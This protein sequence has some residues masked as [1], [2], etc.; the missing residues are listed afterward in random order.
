M[1]SVPLGGVIVGVPDGR[2]TRPPTTIG[3]FQCPCAAGSDDQQR[4]CPAADSSVRPLIVHVQEAAGDHRA[5]AR[6]AV[7]PILAGAGGPRQDVRRRAGVVGDEH[8]VARCR[9]RR[10]EHLSPPRRTRLYSPEPGSRAAASLELSRSSSEHAV[11]AALD[12]QLQPRLAAAPPAP[13]CRGRC[14]SRSAAPGSSASSC[15]VCAGVRA[16]LEHAVAPVGRAVERPVSG[17]DQDRRVPAR[18]RRRHG[19][20]SRSR[21]VSRAG[22]RRVDQ[23]VT[24]RALRVPDRDVIRSIPSIARHGL[25]RAGCRRSTRRSRRSRAPG[26]VQPPFDLLVPRVE[27]DPC[28]PGL[29]TRP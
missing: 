9:P 23:L 10:G 8:V 3:L 17:R 18:P 16:Q 4:R 21:L 27:R 7:L 6:G 20:R 25:R 13:C 5:R 22:A 12:R 15:G 26:D 28:R 1:S 2:I 11:L 19:P 14:R 29:L 24:V